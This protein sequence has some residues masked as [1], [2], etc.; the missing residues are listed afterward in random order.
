MHL[1]LIK[2]PGQKPNQLDMP[3]IGAVF[4]HNF[5]KIKNELAR[6][7]LAVGRLKIDFFFAF[8]RSAKLKYLFIRSL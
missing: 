7:S 2:M 4:G 6:D 1:V 3:I 5:L 8:P